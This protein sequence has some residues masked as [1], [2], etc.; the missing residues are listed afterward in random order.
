MAPRESLPRTDW[1]RQLHGLLLTGVVLSGLLGVLSMSAI[2]IGQPIETS[3][4]SGAV[5]VSDALVGA[6]AGVTADGAI[7]LRILLSRLVGAAHR[8]D[9][10]TSATVRRLRTLGWLL[11]AGGPAASMI[12]FAARFAL[13]GTATTGGASADLDLSTPALWFV[14]GVGLLATSEVIRR[15]QAMRAELDTVV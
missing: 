2:L 13:S 5:L 3:A 12:E 1:L 8:A 14:A 9:P 10:F 4:P 7:D 11:V 6:D 15:G